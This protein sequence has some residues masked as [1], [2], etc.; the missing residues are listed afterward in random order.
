[1]ETQEVADFLMQ[2][3]Y[4]ADALHGDLSP[5]AQRYGNEEVQIEEHDILV[6]TDVAARGLM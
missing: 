1:M 4:A 6:A 5:Q 3:G 2:N